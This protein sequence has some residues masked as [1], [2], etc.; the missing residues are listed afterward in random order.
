MVCGQNNIPTIEKVELKV[1]D[2]RI[3]DKSNVFIRVR[4]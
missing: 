3:S 2:E 1:N 4:N